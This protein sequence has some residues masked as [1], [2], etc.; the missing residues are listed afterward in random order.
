MAT[1][2]Y[3]KKCLLGHTNMYVFMHAYMYER[4]PRSCKEYMMY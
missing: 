2:Q 3:F 4:S 1:G